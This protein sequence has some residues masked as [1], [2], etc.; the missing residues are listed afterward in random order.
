MRSGAQL[1]LAIGAL[2]GCL[3]ALSACGGSAPE[4]IPAKP[5]ARASAPVAPP[6]FEQVIDDTEEAVVRVLVR[7]CL[8][9]GSGTGF[10]VGPRLVATAAHVVAGT[11]YVSL[12][13]HTGATTGARVVG[14]DPERDLALLQAERELP[15]RALRFGSKRGPRLGAEV[16]ALGFPL[17]LP[18]TITRGTISGLDREV[19]IDGQTLFGLMQT[20]A[21]VNPGNSGGPLVQ[22]S[23]EVVGVVVAGGELVQS[24]GFGV[25]AG[26]A[27]HLIDR[28]RENP[29]P[30]GVSAPC[31][32]QPYEEPDYEEPDYE[33]S[34]PSPLEAAASPEEVILQHWQAIA[35]GDYGTAFSLFVPSYRSSN[36]SWI[37]DKLATLPNIDLDSLTVYPSGE[38]GGS[39]S[40]SLDLVAADTAGAEAGVC[41]NF[42]GEV[43]LRLIDGAWRY[44]PGRTLDS[45]PIDPTEDRCLRVAG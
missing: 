1:V 11:E 23:G 32:P 35:A 27:R 33:D 12:V 6:T 15:G 20:D 37:E 39:A 34:P 16:V 22:R 26:E 7:S 21:A 28:W 24:I 31:L 2:L 41:R 38:S 25:P 3:L 18:L 8:G 19:P 13:D 9:E 10:M 43:T 30:N 45:V 17:G 36:P 40:L 44:E 14:F 42:V 29:D 5:A 4:A